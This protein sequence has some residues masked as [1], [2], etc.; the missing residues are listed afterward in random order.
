MA[1]EP[2]LPGA[3]PLLIEQFGLPLLR[4]LAVLHQQA[5]QGNG[6]LPVIAL[7][8]PVGAGKSTLGRQ[9]EALAPRF[10]LR[11]MVASIDDLYWPLA[12][13]QRRLA[14]NP[15]GVNRVPPG[16]HDIP[17]L[18]GALDRWRGGSE[19]ELPHFDK[20]LAAGQG[21]R[22]GWRRQ[23]AD[24]LVVEGWLMGCLPVP[25]EHLGP[26][27]SAATTDGAPAL[28]ED[29]WAWLP[30]WNQALEAY[31][32][33]W[34]ACD[35]LWLLRPLHWNLPRRWRF[36]AEAR[37]RRAG[38]AWLD[39]SALAA[40]VRSSLCSLP[41]AHYQDPLLRHWRGEPP[42]AFTRESD[43][44][45]LCR[46]SDDG[47]APPREVFGVEPVNGTAH[48]SAGL[49]G[50]PADVRHDLLPL[51]AVAVLDGR[52]RCLRVWRQSSPS[53]SSATG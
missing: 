42:I 11:L 12:E 52:R 26:L 3:D 1:A 14:G 27:R 5:Q 18:L 43:R 24:A 7:N 25:A 4:R 31:R 47:W 48:E 22:A 21:D 2:F 19:L 13:R 9:L 41:P 53:A 51:G 23:A 30:H 28:S 44:N 50:P 37:Q 15:F 34:Q 45:P 20:T 46:G 36:Q 39:P 38:G 16:S 40:L 33:L 6:R 32:P 29:E 17:L 8:G 49:L 35:G 10:G